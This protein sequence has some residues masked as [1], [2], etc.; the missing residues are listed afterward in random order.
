[1]PVMITKYNNSIHREA[2]IDLWRKVFGYDSPHN[3]PG[4]AIDKKLV[5]DDWIFVALDGKKLVGSILAGYDGHRGWIYSLAV[6]PEYRK[7]GIGKALLEHAEKYLSEAGCVKINLQ[8]LEGNES[9]EAFYKKQGY[10]TEKRISMG[11][12]LP[13]NVPNRRKS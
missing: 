9:V 6:D 13:H 12:K 4:L 10:Q 11:K 8:I 7:S 1:M 3:E 5:V 2:V